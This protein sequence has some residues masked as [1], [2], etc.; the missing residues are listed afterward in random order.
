MGTHHSDSHRKRIAWNTVRHQRTLRRRLLRSQRTEDRTDPFRHGPAEYADGRIRERL[1]SEPGVPRSQRVRGLDR[2]RAV[3]QCING[4]TRRAE[5]FPTHTHGARK[6]SRCTDTDRP[7][8]SGQRP[9][10]SA[11]RPRPNHGFGFERHRRHTRIC[12]RCHRRRRTHHVVGAAEHHRTGRPETDADSQS[13]RADPGHRPG[14]HAGTRHPA[15]AADQ[16]RGESRQRAA[17]ARAARTLGRYASNHSNCPLPL[18]HR[19]DRPEH[20]RLGTGPRSDGARLRPGAAH[21]PRRG[22]R[23][24]CRRNPDRRFGSAG[25]GLIRQPHRHR[26]LWRW[27]DHFG[28]R[29]AIPHLDHGDGDATSDRRTRRGT[30]VRSGRFGDFAGGTA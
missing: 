26:H 25:L 23:H 28:C 24:R 10:R 3:Q 21:R 16:R 5:P 22:R 20:H 18:R 14:H 13:S 1:E 11:F 4:D 30:C 6:Y 12:L 7:G 9:R 2:P 29:T 17:G 8:A 19:Q 15:V 27:P